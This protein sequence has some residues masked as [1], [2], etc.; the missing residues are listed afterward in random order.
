[1]SEEQHYRMRLSSRDTPYQSPSAITTTEVESLAAF[2]KEAASNDSSSSSPTHSRHRRRSSNVQNRGRKS[3]HSQNR[4]W[5]ATHSQGPRSP[6][7][8]SPKPTNDFTDNKNGVRAWQRSAESAGG[9]GNI[10]SD[11]RI[12][13]T[14]PVNRTRDARVDKHASLRNSSPRPSTCVN[15]TPSQTHK[16]QHQPRQQQKQA[17][18][19]RGTRITSQHILFWGGPLS[20]WNIGFP[21][22]GRHAMDLL[23][24]RLGEAGIKAHPS[25]TAL[26]TELM[27]R[28]DFVCGE[29]FM[30]ACKGWLFERMLPGA[31]LDTANM[32]DTH[33]QRI[34][35]K[36][37]HFYDDTQAQ[38][39][40][41]TSTPVLDGQGIDYEAL[42]NGTMVSC[43]NT[44]SPRDQKAIGRRARGFN[45]PVWTKA[46]TP[47]VVAGSI[48]RAEV[49][50]ELR[51]LYK[52]ASRG[53][54]FVEGSPMDKIWGIG[55]RWDDPR[56]DDEIKWKGENRLGKCH[57]LA[58]AYIRDGKEWA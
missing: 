1:M 50:A 7:R 31:E 44:P 48:A 15:G 24:T 46:S 36:V 8:Q 10:K 56:A 5:R 12:S 52:G 49:D 29:Q 9:H 57:D 39:K 4:N 35:D 13:S 58:A 45:E 30:M 42:H 53:R 28:H 11:K 55:L 47:V 43:I 2:L 14:S 51:A 17:P 20:N 54:K 33:I 23:I 27:A 21:F 34:C 40:T 37:L 32:Q 22:S 3:S 26:A 41:E 18:A 19:A 16:N 6:P 38:D 25:R